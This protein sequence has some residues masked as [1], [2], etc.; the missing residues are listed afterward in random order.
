MLIAYRKLAHIEPRGRGDTA[1][2]GSTRFSQVACSAPSLPHHSHTPLSGEANP[3]HTVPIFDFPFFL[4]TTTSAE[5]QQKRAIV[6]LLSPRGNEGEV[7][8]WLLHSSLAAAAAAA[9]RRIGV[10]R[11]RTPY[12]G[13]PPHRRVL[14]RDRGLNF[15]LSLCKYLYQ[16]DTLTL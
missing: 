10:H 9:K 6:D 3:I 15:P 5:Q 8:T 2:A 13:H 12:I 7:D 1:D 16:F 14:A 4:V 11:Q